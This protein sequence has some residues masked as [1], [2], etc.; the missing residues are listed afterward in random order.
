MSQLNALVNEAQ[1]LSALT[2]LSQKYRIGITGEVFL[3]VMETGS[4]GDDERAYGC[5][6]NSKLRFD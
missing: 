5:D 3:F 4:H 2:E 6:P 1:F